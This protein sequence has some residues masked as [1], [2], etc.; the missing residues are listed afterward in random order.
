MMMG[1]VNSRREAVIQFVVLG[2]NHQR[3]AIKAVIDTG[4][5]GFLTLPSAIISK[6]G[7]TWYM[8]EEGILGD[9]SLSMFNVFEATVI[10]DGQIKSIEIN[11]SETDPLVGMG[12]LEGYELN[13][14]GFA[15]GLVTIKPLP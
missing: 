4:Y 14:Q 15:G 2:E 8:Q 9:G 13:I 5:T 11:E 12:L 10:W 7:L 3:Q 6:L 1:S